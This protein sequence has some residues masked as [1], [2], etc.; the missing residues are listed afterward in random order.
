MQMS[1]S[2]AGIIKKPHEHMAFRHEDE[3]IKR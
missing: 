3:D 2:H 1:M